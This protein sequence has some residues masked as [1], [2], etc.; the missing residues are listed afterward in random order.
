M[1]LYTCMCVRAFEGKRRSGGQRMRWLDSS[2]TQWIWIWAKSRKE[3]KTEEPSNL[4][5]TGSQ[6]V[7]HDL[8]TEQQQTHIYISPISMYVDIYIH[9]YIHMY[10]SIYVCLYTRMH[11]FLYTFTTRWT[12]KYFALLAWR[13]SWFCHINVVQ[14]SCYR[15]RPGDRKTSFKEKYLKY[16]LKI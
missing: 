11:T 6:R 14:I 3:W 10:V 13:I 5:S 12:T 4:R 1:Y 9:T 8:A 2:P 16:H 7:G 15:R